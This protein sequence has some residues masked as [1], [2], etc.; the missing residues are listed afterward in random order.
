MSTPRPEKVAVGCPPARSSWTRLA[1]AS[2][3]APYDCYQPVQLFDFDEPWNGP[4]NCKLVDRMPS[5]YSCP[6]ATHDQQGQTSYVAVVGPHTAWPGASARNVSDIT[7]GT[8]STVLVLEC[9]D[10]NIRWL[11][12]RDL[13]LSV[14]LEVLASEDMAA[15]GSHKSEGFFYQYYHGRNMAM[16]DGSVRF[17][18]NRV[19]QEVWSTLF[20][21]NDGTAWDDRDLSARFTRGRQINVGNCIR[22]GVFIVLALFPLPWVWLNPT[23]S[24]G[25]RRS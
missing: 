10:Q 20:I 4:D 21:L 6:S 25:A 7:D 22:L 12:T 24:V 17:A 16:A 1:V 15:A 8:T 11:E 18:E 23:S 3:V 14:A 13:E 2:T 19:N 5:I 9:N